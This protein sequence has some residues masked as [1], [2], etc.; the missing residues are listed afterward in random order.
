MIDQFKRNIDYIRISVTDR[1]NLRCIYCIP[2]GGVRLVP[3]ESILTYEEWIRLCQYLAKLGIKK[4]KITGGEPLVRK[5]LPFLIG[6]LTKIKGIEQ[7]T[8]TTNG[9]LLK[10]QMKD[11]AKAGLNAVNVSLDT[12]SKGEFAAL[13]RFD[14]L[15]Q[16]LDGVEEALKYPS[17]RV[18]LNCVPLKSYNDKA[19]ILNMASFAREHNLHV[20]FIEIMPLG[21]GREVI[22]YAEEEI[23]EFIGSEFG[24]LI[25]FKEEIGNGPSHYYSL[26]GFQGKIGFISAVSHQFCDNCNRIRLTS[27]GFLKNCLQYASGVNLRELLRN[28]TSDSEIMEAIKSSIYGKPKRH[29]FDQTLK[30]IE[31]DKRIMSQIGG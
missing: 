13:T 30:H 28:G 24:E 18:K 26:K 25:P 16:V 23:K 31:Q 5:N 6:E 22:G 29:T 4:V 14:V 15:H 27:E 12:L 9:V 10:E 20:R 19:G 3:H 2:E 21:Y 7:V 8:L 11:I 1:C 17:I